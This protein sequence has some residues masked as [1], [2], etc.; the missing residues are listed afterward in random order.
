[1]NDPYVYPGTDI[2]RNI[3]GIKDKEKLS[4]FEQNTVSS[5]MEDLDYI[6]HDIRTPQDIKNLHKYLF[7]EVYEWAGEY[8]TISIEKPERVL[9]G[10]SVPYSKPEDIENHLEKI[11]ERASKNQPSQMN[12][13]EFKNHVTKI[14][15]DVW[16]VHPFR[17]GN[18]RTTY[19]FAKAYTEMYGFEFDNELIKKN[20]QFFRDSLTIANFYNDEYPQTEEDLKY[21]RCIIGDSIQKTE[22]RNLEKEKDLEME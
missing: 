8:R 22:E 13:E 7:G 2:L 5:I 1:M 10:Q 16:K 9:A 20:P 3:K 21:A 18:T 19:A 6:Q 12:T 4:E 14:T 15:A 11:L 17:E